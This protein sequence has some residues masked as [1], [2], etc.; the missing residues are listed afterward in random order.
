MLQILLLFSFF[1]G[2]KSMNDAE[3]F[4]IFEIYEHVLN[5][6]LRRHEKCGMHRKIRTEKP[7]KE[8][9]LLQNWRSHIGKGS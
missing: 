4:E 2:I 5:A 7:E 3:I 6:V 1:S 9:K 8:M